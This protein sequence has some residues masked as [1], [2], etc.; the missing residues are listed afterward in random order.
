MGRATIPR[1]P[2]RRPA[3]RRAALQRRCAG[4]LADL[5]LGSD[6]GCSVRLPAAACDIVGLKS[7]WG[8]IPKEGAFPLCPT[9]DTAGPMADSVEDVTLMWSVLADRPIPEPRLAGLTVGLL[10]DAPAVGDSHEPEPSNLAE[11]WVADLER[12]GARVVEARIPEPAANTWPQ[13]DHEALRPLIARRFRPERMST[14]R[15]FA[16]SS[17][18]PSG[19]S[20]TTSRAAYDAMHEW[21]RY[22]PDVDIYVSPCYAI[23]LPPEDV[24]GEG[25]PTRSSPRSYAG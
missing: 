10:R 8:L 22:E 7:Q 16:R 11:E 2:A 19:S 3:A 15:S 23:D 5:A 12:L 13:F 1:T 6:T 24:D 18:E 4:H 20:P 9:L 21:R 25:S 17:S 14:A